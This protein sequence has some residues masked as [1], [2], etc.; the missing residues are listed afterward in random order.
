MILI[1]TM[2]T[3]SALLPIVIGSFVLSKSRLLLWFWL[4]LLYGF[5]TDQLSMI[6]VL[7]DRPP[8]VAQLAIYNQNVYSLVEAVFL[9]AFIGQLYPSS[10]RKMWFWVISL[11]LGFTWVYFYLW[12]G[13][14]FATT[15]TMN[16]GFDAFYHI[17]LSVISAWTLISMTTTKTNL[18]RSHF[19]LC[20]GVFFY[21]FCIFTLNA[22][23][24]SKLVG[25][26]WFLGSMLNIV[27]MVIYAVGFY[28]SI[29]ELKSE[30]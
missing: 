2:S 22:L 4:F 11:L 19:Y 24:E 28:T 14:D 18:L 23:I 17:V 16:A 30:K 21:S 29:Q 7:L 25:S 15:R 13:D 12:S 26:F 6:Y 20:I 1:Q 8:V 5:L 27:A 9:S 3:Y 10:N